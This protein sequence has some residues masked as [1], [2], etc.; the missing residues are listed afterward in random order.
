MVRVKEAIYDISTMND[1]AFLIRDL[2]A[3][4]QLFQLRH[5][6]NCFFIWKIIIIKIYLCRLISDFID[7]IM[8]V[9]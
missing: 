2:F 7:S 8:Y 3:R 5:E 1:Y 6:N 4:R 9:F